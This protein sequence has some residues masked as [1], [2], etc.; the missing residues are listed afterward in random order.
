MGI[1]AR[2]IHV[3]FAVRG[4]EAPNGR[5][6]AEQCALDDLRAVQCVAECPTDTNIIERLAAM[7]E[8]K[9]GFALGRAYVDLEVGVSLEKGH[10]FVG[11]EE[12]EGIHIAVSVI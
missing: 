6:V 3:A 1:H 10:A 4:K 8:G 7:I 2:E 11:S 12:R 9:D 5:A